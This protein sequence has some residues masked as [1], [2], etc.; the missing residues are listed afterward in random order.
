MRQEL[1][2]ELVCP[3]CKGVLKSVQFDGEETI[4]NGLLT[5]AACEV[6][7]PIINYI[8][9][10]F[11]YQSR[12]AE[13]WVQQRQDQIN[14]PSY[15]LPGGAPSPGENFV[16]R[17]FSAQ[18]EG[19][20]IS[21][22]LQY[23]YN[24]QDLLHIAQVQLGFGPEWFKGKRILNCGCGAGKEAI[25]LQRASETTVFAFDLNFSLLRLGERVKKY[26]NIHF[27]LASV[28]NI[29]LRRQS[30]DY[31]YSHGVLHHTYSTEKAVKALAQFVRPG[32]YYYFWIY[33][34]RP[35][36]KFHHAFTLPF[37]E[38]VLRPIISRLSGLPQ[39]IALFPFVLRTHLVNLRK[40]RQ[41]GL[42]NKPT[43][44]NSWLMESDYFT[45]LYAH[46]H[47]MGEAILW[48]KEIG[49][50]DITPLELEKIP[51]RYLHVWL[52]NVGLRSRRPMTG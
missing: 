51:P 11:D 49:F 19:L 5:C 1:L 22:G 28:W 30:F 36:K 34:I 38:R 10:M 20:D 50:E 4:R 43:W 23:N 12:V 45:P 29:P 40:Y 3:Q 46:W 13:E 37:Q 14:L 2:A 6:M 16:Q 44:H 18:W 47:P 27:F 52:H 35:A 25:M 9:V 17:S 33:G 26:P 7:Y 48:L 42:L 21:E 8:P 32:G 39:Q 41:G 24:D 15:R 31:V